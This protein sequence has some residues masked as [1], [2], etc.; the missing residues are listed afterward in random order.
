MGTIPSAKPGIG[1][2][3]ANGEFLNYT[4]IVLLLYPGPDIGLVPTFVQVHSCLS[5]CL[6]GWSEQLGEGAERRL[7][8]NYP[9]SKVSGAHPA[10]G[11]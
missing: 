1:R 4:D 10:C 3:S 9:P 2:A 11:L 7:L 6:W 8:H 5:L